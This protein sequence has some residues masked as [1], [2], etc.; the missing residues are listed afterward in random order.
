MYICPIPYNTHTMNLASPEEA[1]EEEIQVKDLS[2]FPDPAKARSSLPMKAFD[3]DM[4]LLQ[5]MRTVTDLEAFE[6][7][8]LTLNGDVSEYGFQRVLQIAVYE[9]YNYFLPFLKEAM[10]ETAF[11]KALE[12]QL[13]DDFMYVY[14]TMLTLLLRPDPH[15]T[16]A[17]YEDE[18]QVQ[19]FKD[20]IKNYIKENEE[21]EADEEASEAKSV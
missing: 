16:D 10:G 18:L 19:L 5:E 8:F 11:S 7:D 20:Y 2:V 9:K 6:T 4:D 1:K 15:R 3:Y 14:S 13:F 17:E 12:E 21:S